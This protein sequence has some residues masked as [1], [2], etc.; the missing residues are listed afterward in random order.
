MPYVAPFALYLLLVSVRSSQNVV[1]LYP[2]SAAAV[3]ATLWFFR[4]RY[5][6]LQS[7][8]WGAAA[9]RGPGAATRLP[10]VWATAVGVG[11]LAIVVWIGIDPYYPQ[12]GTTELF[13]PRGRWLFIGFRVAGAALVV[14]VMEELFWRGFLLRWLINEDF[15][16][17]PV[18]TFTWSSFLITTVLFGFEHHQW[19]AGL[20]CGALY[21]WLCYRYK[22]VF[23]CVVAHAV[24]NAAL[25]AWVLT[26]SAWQFW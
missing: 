9:V 20:V 17:V 4:G 21:N 19:L 15:K 22:D 5:D 1:W 23:A 11:L 14:P 13:D 8:L 3:A 2:L 6:E 26:N 10:I 18:G 12:L 7:P 24:S 16:R 25:A